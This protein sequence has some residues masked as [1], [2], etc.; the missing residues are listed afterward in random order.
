MEE[1]LL[2]A[3][4]RGTDVHLANN[5]GKVLDYLL[6]ENEKIFQIFTALLIRS[7]YWP[8]LMFGFWQSWTIREQ[9]MKRCESSSVHSA[10][11]CVRALTEI[12][13]YLSHSVDISESMKLPLRISCKVFS[14]MSLLL[15]IPVEADEDLVELSEFLANSPQISA[16]AK[17]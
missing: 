4:P 13:E 12:I 17:W 16:I 9:A 1:Y 5:I 14:L 11:E 6:Y 10:R 15:T 7:V 8:N 3:F 2:L